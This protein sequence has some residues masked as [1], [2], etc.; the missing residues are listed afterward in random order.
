MFYIETPL[1]RN[2]CFVEISFLLIHRG[3][4]YWKP[5]TAE[6]QSHQEYNLHSLSCLNPLTRLGQVFMLLLP[7]SFLPSYRSFSSSSVFSVFSL[8]NSDHILLCPV[9]TGHVT[10]SSIKSSF[11]ELTNSFGVEL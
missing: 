4:S 5:V 2:T 6:Y 9:V 11:L 8:C 1:E 10:G 7:Y 3:I